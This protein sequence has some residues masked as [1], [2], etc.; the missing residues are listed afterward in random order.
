MNGAV[1]PAGGSHT[2]SVCMVCPWVEEIHWGWG[3]GSVMGPAMS[4]NGADL[5]KGPGEQNSVRA[6]LLTGRPLI[7]PDCCGPPLSGGSPVGLGPAQ[8]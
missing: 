4:W 1:F 5:G 3:L 7:V 6:A 2:G 8:H